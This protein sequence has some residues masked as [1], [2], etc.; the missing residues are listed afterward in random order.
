MLNGPGDWQKTTP[1]TNLKTK[2]SSA[3]V[4]KF[5]NTEEV[6]VSVLMRPASKIMRRSRKK[7][8]ISSLVENGSMII[9]MPNIET[10][11]DELKGLKDEFQNKDMLYGIKRLFSPFIFTSVCLVAGPAS[12]ANVRTYNQQRKDCCS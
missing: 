1:F 2:V 8:W 4:L 3:P 11:Y 12:S 10:P 7:C 5:F 6:T 9:F